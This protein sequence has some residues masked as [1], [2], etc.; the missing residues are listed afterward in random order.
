MG[1]QLDTGDCSC[2]AQV[3]GGA[4]HRGV[5]TVI[6]A[7]L[8]IAVCAELDHSHEEIWRVAEATCLIIFGVEMLVKMSTQRRGFWRSKWNVFDLTVIALSALPMVVAGLDLSV[9]RVT[10]VARVLHLAR[11]V[12]HLRLLDL[13]RRRNREQLSLS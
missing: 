4:F 13:L 12:T 11:H 9:L 8:A 2:G 3:S 10:R 7:N 5:N 1:C 6:V